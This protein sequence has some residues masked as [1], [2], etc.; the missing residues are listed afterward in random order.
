MQDL[1]EDE[2]AGGAIF[3]AGFVMI[4]KK[5][6]MPKK[7][8]DLV[9]EWLEGS[10]NYIKIKSKCKDIIVILSDNDLYV[11]LENAKLFK[12]NLNAKM[13]IEHNKG[14]SPGDE[15]LFKELLGMIN[16]K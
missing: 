6:K 5:N 15:S 10:L 1:G 12:N 2:S 3:T 8:Q 13:F 14:H 11:P 4:N 9:S 7:E 16:K